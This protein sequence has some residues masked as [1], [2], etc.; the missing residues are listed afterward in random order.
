MKSKDGNESPPQEIPVIVDHVL[1]YAAYSI[2]NSPHDLVI[3]A[4]V[5][6]FSVEEI[7]TARDVLWR[8]CAQH[9]P[10]M[11]RRKH[12]TT[13]PGLTATM[14]DVVEAI[15]KL[16][17]D[18]V[19]NPRYAVHFTNLGRIPRSKPSEKCSISMCDR[20]A[21]LESREDQRDE[22]I[23]SMQEEIAKLQRRD[24][25]PSLSSYAAVTTTSPVRSTAP[26]PA[27]PSTCVAPDGQRRACTILSNGIEQAS[28]RPPPPHTKES[29]ASPSDDGF[30]AVRGKKRR[31]RKDRVMGVRT[32]CRLQGAPEPVKD[33]YVGRLLPQYDVEDITLHMQDEGIA[34][35]DIQR[36]SSDTAPFASFRVRVSLASESKALSSHHWPKG[37]VV[38]RFYSPRPKKHTGTEQK[39][40]V[41][42]D[43]AV[44]SEVEDPAAPTAQQVGD[45]NIDDDATRAKALIDDNQQQDGQHEL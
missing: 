31:N 26:L 41:T 27:V 5:E 23:R 32:G 28:L 25:L 29:K 45:S 33:I 37:A 1:A 44:S 22:M 8:E 43:D 4:C 40:N 2:D 42:P 18:G 17:N 14:K 35:L 34:C 3:E 13:K 30:V 36:L 10:K 24:T 9:L 12:I 7:C 20:L 16:N 39:K 6:F 19:I 15:D 38:G 11:S 21:R